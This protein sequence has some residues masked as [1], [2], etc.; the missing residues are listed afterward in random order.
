MLVQKAPHFCCQQAASIQ[1]VSRVDLP[2]AVRQFLC[3]CV[4]HQRVEET[5]ACNVKCKNGYDCGDATDEPSCSG[6][7]NHMNRASSAS[8]SSSGRTL[9][10]KPGEGKE[11]D[12]HLQ[13]QLQMI[14]QVLINRV[15]I[16]S[17]TSEYRR[18]LSATFWLGE[19]TQTLFMMRLLSPL[20]PSWP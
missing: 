20:V 19:E 10:R 13:R 2:V 11:T 8:S 3:A 17:P 5:F 7:F 12:G 6:V 18:R 1:Q 4:S 14:M 15:W 16:S 9:S